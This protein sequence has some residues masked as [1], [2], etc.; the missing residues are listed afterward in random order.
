MARWFLFK[1]LKLLRYGPALEYEFLKVENKILHQKLK[2]KEL[3]EKQKSKINLIKKESVIL[4]PRL[5]VQ[6]SL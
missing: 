1:I 3:K 6:K 4:L 2:E 5:L